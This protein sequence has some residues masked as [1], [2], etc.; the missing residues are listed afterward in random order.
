[1]QILSHMFAVLQGLQAGWLWD[2][3][4]TCQPVDYS[5]NPVA[6]RVRIR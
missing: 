6:L 3:S 2:Y 5:N 1:M 4:Y